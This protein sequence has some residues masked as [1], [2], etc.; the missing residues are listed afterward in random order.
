M[1]ETAIDPSDLDHRAFQH[2]TVLLEETLRALDPRSGRT[3]ADATLGGGGHAEGILER[4][5][6]DGRLVGIDRDPA[7]LDA[8]RAR[9]ARFGDRVTFLHASFGELEHALGQAGVTRVHGVVADLGVSSPQL[10]WAERGFSL[11]ARGP[12][13]MRMDPT[14]GETALELIARLDERELADVLYQLGEER[15]SRPI[16]RSIR[17]ALEQGELETTEDLRRAVVRVL[18]PRPVG[19]IDPATRTFQ[20]LRIAVNDELG[21]LDALLDSLP[22]V[23][24][25]DGVA[26]IISFHSLEDRRVKHTLRD[27]DALEPLTK[28]PVLAGDEELAANPRARSAKLRAARRLPRVDSNLGAGVSP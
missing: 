25:N 26:A 10:D 28:K 8:A 3:Y 23:L 16:A 22:N 6:P 7:A 15:R 5:G 24:A 13:D 1:T 14:R 17:R 20:A 11:R 21:Q 18:G 12:L 19:G 27:S 9:L 2:R 4:S